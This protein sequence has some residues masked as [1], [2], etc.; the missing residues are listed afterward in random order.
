VLQ[1]PLQS[2]MI[3]SAKGMAPFSL[4]QPQLMRYMV[5]LSAPHRHVAA[6][7][8][9]DAAARECG[10][11]LVDHRLTDVNWTPN[12]A[13][14][15][16]PPAYRLCMW[17]ESAGQLH[18]EEASG[19]STTAETVKRSASRQ[20]LEA[21]YPYGFELLMKFASSFLGTQGIEEV[22]QL[23]AAAHRVVGFSAAQHAAH[24]CAVRRVIEALHRFSGSQC[25]A[26]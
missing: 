3:G 25:S 18:A 4:P 22:G 12:S 13:L 19:R 23:Y 5:T 6:G 21:E 26:G 1:F 9:H 14:R 15:P 11:E 20:Q 24:V 16:L 7:A 10:S 8:R 17:G 2:W